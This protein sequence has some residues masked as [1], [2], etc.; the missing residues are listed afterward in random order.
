MCWEVI[1]R[2]LLEELFPDN[3]NA[4]GLDLC[5]RGISERVKGREGREGGLRT[6]VGAPVDADDGDVLEEDKVE[7]E[8]RVGGRTGQL[9]GTR[10]HWEERWDGARLLDLPCGEA[11]DDGPAFP[12][13]AL[14]RVCR[15]SARSISYSLSMFGRPE[16]MTKAHRG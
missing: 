16:Q 4:C 15:T 2:S 1:E 6:G 7:R 8:L 5:M 9:P 13:N 14:E 10:A 3:G 11:D 12:R